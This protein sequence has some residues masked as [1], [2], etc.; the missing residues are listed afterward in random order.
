MTA[1]PASFTLDGTNQYFY[2]F[3]ENDFWTNSCN[4]ES[5]WQSADCYKNTNIFALDSYGS[6]D[7]GF[8]L[9]TTSNTGLFTIKPSMRDLI[10]NQFVTHHIR[11]S[12]GTV[13]AA[14]YWLFTVSDPCLISNVMQFT[15][16]VRDSY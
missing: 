5:N 7:W 11:D 10:G 1:D 15:Y 14:N 6:F 2:V 8:V 4:F 13:V 16:A 12:A 9:K 3:T